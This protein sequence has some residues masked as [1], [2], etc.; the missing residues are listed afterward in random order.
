MPAF[1]PNTTTTDKFPTS[2]GAQVGVGD[3]FASGYFVVANAAAFVQYQHGV[4]SQADPSQEIYCPPATYPLYGTDTDPLGGLKFRSAVT[5]VP[6]QVFG[7]LYKKGEASLLAGSEF[8]ATVAPGGGITVGGNMITGIVSGAGLIVAGTGF[9][10]VRNGVGDYSVT[11][12][13][14]FAAVPVVLCQTADFISGEVNGLVNSLATGFRL[15]WTA[16]ADH[17]FNFIAQTIT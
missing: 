3:V 6:A 9:T 4:Y 11:Y 5:G 17:A 12:T 2:G 14:A 1:L 13:T 16:A 15:R 7:V 10:V 8:A